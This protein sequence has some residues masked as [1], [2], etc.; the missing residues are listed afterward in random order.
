MAEEPTAW[1]QGLS[2][3]TGRRPRAEGTFRTGCWREYNGGKVAGMAMDARTMRGGPK[4]AGCDGWKWA[5]SAMA[6]MGE[7]EDR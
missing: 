7:E 3:A 6:M 1:L 4:N 2:V 5:W